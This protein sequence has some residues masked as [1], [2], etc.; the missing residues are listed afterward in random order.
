ME[1]K[2]PSRITVEMTNDCNLDCQM[3]PRQNTIDSSQIKYM[4]WDLW[5][6]IINEIK[7]KNMT[8]VPFWRGESMMHLDFKKMIDLA[9]DSVK[10]IQFATN[11]IL[12]EKYLDRL[13]RFDFISISYH[14]KHAAAAIKLLDK[15]RD[16][17]TLTL[18]VSVVRGEISV[19][20]IL[21]LKPYVDIIRIYDAHS[22]TGKL[23]SK[24]NLG[25]RLFCQKL[26]NDITIDCIGNVSRCCHNWQTEKPMNI[27]NISIEQA[28]HS[29]KY[30]SIRK[31]YPDS[32]CT[33]CDQWGNQTVGET[34]RIYEHTIAQSK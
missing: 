24:G 28:W 3:C 6:K 27:K 31:D 33:Q 19:E 10:E 15:Y 1:N 13:L 16:R 23:Y 29:E 12:V 34:E 22:E 20:N 18:Q 5:V 21:E 26:N 11:G 25:K 14:T 9:F 4:S 32:I 17:T 8:L 2:F 30:K 7:D